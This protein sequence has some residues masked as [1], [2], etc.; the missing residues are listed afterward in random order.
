MSDVVFTADFT[1]ETQWV[2]G[3][4]WAYPG[5]GPTNPA[6]DKLDHLTA[7]PAY[8]RS[9]TFRATRRADGLW[10]TGLLTT[11]GSA[12]GF[13]VRTG[14]RLDARVRLPVGVGAWPAI[15]TWRDGGNE[16]DV[17]EYHP[18]N[19]ALLEFSNHVRPSGRDLRA[20]AI[21]PGGAVDLSVTFGRRSVVWSL[22]GK[23]VFADGRGVGVGWYASL[24]VNLSVSA[25]RYHPHPDAA[26][27]ELSY[28]VES[29]VVHRTAHWPPGV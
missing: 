26:T 5:G 18:D 21:S 19:P 14:D 27:T 22:N 8:S 15:W 17:F 24:I 10:D 9:G 20:D 2:A 4:S 23:R 16:V 29:L 12:E 11:E 28:T 25:G 13:T 7:D 1:S 3:R 6:D